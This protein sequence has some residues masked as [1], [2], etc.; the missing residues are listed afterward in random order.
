LERDLK[1]VRDQLQNEQR[2]RMVTQ[3]ADPAKKQ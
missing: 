3:S 1:E 2:R